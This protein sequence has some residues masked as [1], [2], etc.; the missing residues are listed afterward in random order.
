MDRVV[1]EDRRR[2]EFRPYRVHDLSWRIRVGK[3]DRRRRDS[4]TGCF[5]LLR[6]RVGTIGIVTVRLVPVVGLP[7]GKEDIGAVPRKHA[8]NGSTDPLPPAGAGD[9]RDLTG[10]V[11]VDFGHRDLPLKPERG[12]VAVR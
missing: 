3:V 4:D 9:D 12:I 10:Q 1:H 7:M 5:Q 2:S 11:Q 6:E 8:A